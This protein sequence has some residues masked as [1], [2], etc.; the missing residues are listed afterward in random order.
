MKAVL[1]VLVLVFVLVG[2][3]PDPSA[4]PVIDEATLAPLLKGY[5]EYG[6][7]PIDYFK[8]NVNC[9][10]N[11][12]VITKC[13]IDK[14]DANTLTIQFVHVGKC[15]DYL[16]NPGNDYELKSVVECPMPVKDGDRYRIDFKGVINSI[17]PADVQLLNKQIDGFAFLTPELGEFTVNLPVSVA[18][19]RQQIISKMD[20]RSNFF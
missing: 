12:M 5:F 11:H 7:K 2:C 20:I 15:T 10:Q 19:K 4:E 17:F 3:R 14:K 9:T 6:T 8:A 1:L 16:K 18:G 13:F